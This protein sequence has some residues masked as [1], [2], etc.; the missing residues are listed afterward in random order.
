MRFFNVIDYLVSSFGEIFGD[1]AVN[2]YERAIHRVL[3]FRF[4][5]RDDAS[6]PL[7][8]VY[9]FDD[10]SAP[11]VYLD[12]NTVYGMHTV[13]PSRILYITRYFGVL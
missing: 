5:E 7:Y 13:F 2:G 8:D 1:R 12:G 3:N 6:V 9:S 11:Y 10:G 4:V